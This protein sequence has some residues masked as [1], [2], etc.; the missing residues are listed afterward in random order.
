MNHKEKCGEYVTCT[1]RNSNESHLL[2]KTH[3]HK[4]PFFLT[5]N[6]HFE[7]D[8]NLDNSNIGNKTTNIYKQNPVCN[9]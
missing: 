4:N 8:I 3:F 2:R 7:A 9:G 5:I 6:A 1:I